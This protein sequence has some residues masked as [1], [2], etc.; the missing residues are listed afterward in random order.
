M[1]IITIFLGLLLTTLI[2]IADNKISYLGE[3]YIHRWSKD[4]QHE[5]TPSGQEELK[6]W[7][8][9]LTVNLYP[10]VKS[11]EGLAEVAN[12]LLGLYQQHNALVLKTNSVPR[13]DKKEAEHLIA[14]VLPQKEYLEI[15]F[16]RLAMTDQKAGAIVYSHRIYGT[17][18]GN[19]ASK[20]LEDNA[21]AS[22][23]SLMKLSISN[24]F[25][26]T[27]KKKSK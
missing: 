23:N 24:A 16:T 14:V 10:D 25:L 11:G 18:A 8:D 3:E 20:W 21:Q 26:A 2:A 6:K 9:M 12:K 15:V 4:T 5:F 17:E 13:T 7:E 1:K 19:I 27:E 22:E